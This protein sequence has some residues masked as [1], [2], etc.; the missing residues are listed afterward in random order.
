MAALFPPL[1]MLYSYIFF[2]VLFYHSSTVY[3]AIL[4]LYWI[5]MFFNLDKYPSTTG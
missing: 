3:R 2:I 5:N 1:E 4:T